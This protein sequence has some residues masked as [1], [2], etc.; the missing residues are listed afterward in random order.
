MSVLSG[1]NIL[2]LMLILSTKQEEHIL[3][4]IALITYYDWENN[5]MLTCSVEKCVLMKYYW[6]YWIAVVGGIF[7]PFVITL[8]R[9]LQDNKYGWGRKFK[10]WF[11]FL[12]IGTVVV[13]L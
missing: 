7:T 4:D 11:Q 5:V 2:Y 1:A 6:Y 9:I 10:S 13:R 3:N 12:F 8:Y